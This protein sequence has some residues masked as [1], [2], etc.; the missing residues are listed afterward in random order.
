MLSIYEYSNPKRYGQKFYPLKMSSHWHVVLAL[1]MC[2]SWLAFIVFCFCDLDKVL[3]AQC[4]RHHFQWLFPPCHGMSCWGG[5]VSSYPHAV[6]L[7]EPLYLSK[8]CPPMAMTNDEP[9]CSFPLRA[10]LLRTSRIRMTSDWDGMS[11]TCWKWVIN[12]IFSSRLIHLVQSRM[13]HSSLQGGRKG[14]GET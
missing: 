2:Q 13:I 12:N 4:D 5:H 10:S 11:Q 14:V 3:I 6:H 8:T 1:D 9:F 7:K